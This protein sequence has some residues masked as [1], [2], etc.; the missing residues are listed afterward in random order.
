MRDEVALHFAL[1]ASIDVVSV[2]DAFE[3]SKSVHLLLDLCEGGDL[4][5]G[6]HEA[7]QRSSSNIDALTTKE[8]GEDEGKDEEDQL[9]AFTGFGDGDER[10]TPFSEAAAATA[11]RSV[12][13][14]L[15]A[16]HEH[17]LVHRDVKPAN[18]IWMVGEKG[19][20]HLKL[21]DFGLASTRPKP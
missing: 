3:D 15:A 9:G 19:E 5:T 16:C 6:A 17:G 11:I 4:L 18:F 12:L 1:T 8:L 20:R 21:S 10:W 14:A 7:L 13:R 2:H